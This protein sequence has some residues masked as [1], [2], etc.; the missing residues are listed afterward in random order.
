ML[1]TEKSLTSAEYA[2]AQIEKELLAIV[3]SCKKFHSYIYGR[4]D[5]VVETDHLPLVRIFE[6]PLHLVPLRLQRM[7]MTLQ[8]Y[9]FKLVGKSGKDIPV[10]DALSRAYLPNTYPKLLQEGSFTNVYAVEVR[11][12]TAFSERR[13]KQLAA[14]TEKDQQLQKVKQA[15][16]NGWTGKV[17]PE[18]RPFAHVQDEL[19]YIDGILFKGDRVVIPSTLREDMVQIIHEGHQGIVRSKQLARDI[20]YWPG[21]NDKITDVVNKCAVCQSARNRQQREP[22]K[23]SEIPEGPW[24]VVAADLL[25]CVDSKFLVVVDYYSDF[26]EIEELKNNTLSTTV[27]ESLAKMFAVHGIPEKLLTDNGPQFIS[28][29]F[30]DF[31]RQ[32]NFVHVTTSPHHHQAN[33]MVERA[34]Q[35]VRRILEKTDGDRIKAFLCLLQ[36]RNTPK[37]PE[38]GSPAQRLFGRRVQTKLPIS[39]KLLEPKIQDPKKVK[40]AILQNRQ[41]AKKY[42]DRGTKSLSPLALDDTI[43]VRQGRTWQPARHIPSQTTAP[44]SCNIQTES[45]SILRRNRRDLLHTN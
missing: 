14:E 44:R 33:G 18:I 37:V 15:I 3:F 7:R 6:K 1:C 2:Y 24:R 27:I 9:S 42:Y 31:V 13:Q 39:Q 45:G 5:V 38:A 17:D 26:I 40:E 10:A 34:N 19:S 11:G 30:K 20:M 29:Q 43:R 41:K 21:M 16:A 25:Q 22:L 35:T 12:T 36:L 8:Q 28:Q 32:W 23:P 4:T